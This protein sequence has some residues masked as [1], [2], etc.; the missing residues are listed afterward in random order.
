MSV[1]E[2]KAVTAPV[3]SA[4]KGLPAKEAAPG[5]TAVQE[6][7]NVVTIE[8]VRRDPEVVAFIQQANASLFALGFTEH[9]QRH[10]GLVGHIAANV[11]ERLDY[12]ERTHQLAE[13]AG[14]LHDIG[15]CIHRQAHAQSSSLM[16]WRILSRLGMPP[17]ECALIMNAIGNHEEERGTAT[18]PVSAA[19][20]IADKADVH[21]SRVQNPTMAEFDIHDRVNYATTRSFVR[22]R[23]EEKVVAL[24]LEIDTNYAQVIEYFEIFLDR[25]T[26]VRQAITFLGCEFQLIINDTRFS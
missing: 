15:N 20:I 18:T 19:L 1:S 5:V 4:S 8:E 10:A 7:G 21:R 17:D 25:M 3:E 26:M 23:P 22:V 24:E 14:Y 12:P 11:L 13:I 16:A 2:K 6:T 9:G